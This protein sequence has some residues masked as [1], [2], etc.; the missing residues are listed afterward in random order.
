MTGFIGQALSVLLKENE[1]L[2]TNAKV[3]GGVVACRVHERQEV[4]NLATGDRKYLW[5][6]EFKNEDDLEMFDA[7]LRAIVDAA[8]G[9]GR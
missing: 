8:T 9:D 7:A 4:R 1:S 3:L 5:T 2:V 6:V